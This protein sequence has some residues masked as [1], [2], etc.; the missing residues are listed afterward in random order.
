[1]NDKPGF[2]KR[3]WIFL[4]SPSAKYSFIGIA[5][6]FF[7]TGIIFWGGFTHKSEI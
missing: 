6:I 4:K 1:M 7:F 5:T 2:I 3:T